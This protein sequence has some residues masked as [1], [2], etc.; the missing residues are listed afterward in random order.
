MRP[1]RVTVQRQRGA[2]G[3]GQVVVQAAGNALVHHRQR[4]LAAKRRHGRAASHRLQHHQAER[5]G[6]AGKHEHIGRGVERWQRVVLLHAQEDRIGKALF[7]PRLVRARPHHHLAARQVQRQKGIQVLLARHAAH[8]Q[9]DRARQMRECLASGRLEF[10][11]VHP[12]RPDLQVAQATTHQHIAHRGRGH[13][14]ALRRP[15]EPAQVAPRQGGG[16]A[17]PRLQVVGEHGVE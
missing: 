8:T 3:L 15:V 9:I 7:Q 1:H 13:Q 17:H 6:Q 16:N 2:A 10:A 11:R 14:H 5:V 4:R 12:A